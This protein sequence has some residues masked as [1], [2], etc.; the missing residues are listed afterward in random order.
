MG[1][2]GL[3]RPACLVCPTTYVGTCMCAMIMAQTVQTCPFAL[4]WPLFWVVYRTGGRRVIEVPAFSR[5][6][7]RF[8][9]C[10]PDGVGL[11]WLCHL[12]R[13]RRGTHSSVSPE[14]TRMT[15]R[16]TLIIRSVKPHAQQA[17]WKWTLVRRMIRKA[18]LADSQLS[19][20]FGMIDRA[21]VC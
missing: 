11:G 18:V 15:V 13:T 12:T 16:Q 5:L 21:V 3:R 4:D 9:H 1:D 19:S 17:S 2:L 20:E 6:Q 14:A 10:A 8:S 7:P